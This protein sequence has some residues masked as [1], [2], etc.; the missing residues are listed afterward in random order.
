MKGSGQFDE[1]PAPVNCGARNFEDL[2]LDLVADRVGAEFCET[3]ALD[4]MESA[5]AGLLVLNWQ[6]HVHALIFDAPYQSEELGA[7][8]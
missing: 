1:C 4:Q 8:F 3:L 6:L 2:C 7:L 5:N